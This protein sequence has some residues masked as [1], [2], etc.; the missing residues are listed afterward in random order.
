MAAMKPRTGDGPLEV[1]KEGRSI[2]LR[3]PL[4]GGGRLVVEMNAE[5]AEALGAA[6]KGCIG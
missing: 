5:E 6:I 4:E 1:T 2:L 3:M